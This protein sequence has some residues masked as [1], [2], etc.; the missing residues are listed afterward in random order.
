MLQVTGVSTDESCP[1]LPGPA[2]DSGCD[3]VKRATFSEEVLD[4]GQMEKSQSYPVLHLEETFYMWIW[5]LRMHMHMC[6]CM[7]AR[8]DGRPWLCQLL[9]S[10][11]L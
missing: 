7:H 1:A 9:Q 10:E 8:C 3:A 5:R 11:V 4:T 6:M 2:P